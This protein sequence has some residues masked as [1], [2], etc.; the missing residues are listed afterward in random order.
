MGL[1]DIIEHLIVL[2]SK[3]ESV[4]DFEDKALVMAVAGAH[5]KGVIEF[6]KPVTSEH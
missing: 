5:N 3:P 2:R 6:M 1:R 4:D